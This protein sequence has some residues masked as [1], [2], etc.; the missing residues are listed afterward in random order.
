[1]YVNSLNRFLIKLMITFF[2]LVILY[3]VTLNALSDSGA[4]QIAAEMGVRLEKTDLIFRPI[5][6][7]KEIIGAQFE[8]ALDFSRHL[9]T[10]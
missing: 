9:P 7:L 8:Y 10:Y 6:T 3:M 2:A 1:M 4:M 5:Y